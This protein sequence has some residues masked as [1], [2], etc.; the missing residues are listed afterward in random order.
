MFQIAPIESASCFHHINI[1]AVQYSC[2]IH[3]A[4]NEELAQQKQK[5]FTDENFFVCVILS[6]LTIGCLAKAVYKSGV[7]DEVMQRFIWRFSWCPTT[8]IRMVRLNFS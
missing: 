1:L 3:H 8:S 5:K 7:K 6:V 2:I 4:L